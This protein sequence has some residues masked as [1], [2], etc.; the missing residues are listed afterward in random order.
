MR[1]LVSGIAGGVFGCGLFLSGMTDTQK[2]KGF[3]DFSS[4]W[5]PTLMFVMA[6]ALLP[7]AIAWRLTRH[8]RPLVGG[9]FPQ[10]PSS[11]IDS[12]LVVGAV[13]FGIGWGLVGLCPGPAMASV[14]YGGIK[15]LVFLAAMI[16]GMLCAAP[17]RRRLD[18]RASVS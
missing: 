3:L 6:G 5:D 7:M 2:V 9:S 10:R 1:L 8:R 11:G 12:P 16:C 4:N 15:G 18:S 13:L 14:S 17:V